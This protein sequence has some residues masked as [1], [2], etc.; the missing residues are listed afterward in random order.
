MTL[1]KM[2]SGDIY[3]SMFYPVIIKNLKV[4]KD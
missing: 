3:I 1:V 2:L 4:L